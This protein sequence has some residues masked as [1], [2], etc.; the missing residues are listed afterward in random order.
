VVLA[1]RQLCQENLQPWAP[2]EAAA[3]PPL[4]PPAAPALPG[5][6]AGPAAGRPAPAPARAGPALADRPE[7][8]QADIRRPSALLRNAVFA[9]VLGA[10]LYLLLHWWARLP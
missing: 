6:P 7:D 10:G 2:A 5:P 4:P 1:T 8:Y 9:A 3:A